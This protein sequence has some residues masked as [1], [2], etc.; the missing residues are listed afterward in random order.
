MRSFIYDIEVMMLDW[1]VVFK[2]IGSGQHVVFH[3]DTENIHD[4]IDGLKDDILI[5]F[6]NKHYDDY[7]LKGIYHGADPTTVKNINDF[8]ILKGK[9]GWEH[10]FLQRKK[11]VFQTADLRDDVVDM[12][13]SL[14]AIEGN[15]NLSIVE[16][17]VS[18]DIDH[19]MTP[20]EVEETIFYCKK[21]VDATE[22]LFFQRKDYMDAK[23]QIAEMYEVDVREAMGMTNAKLCA[24]ILNAEATEF[25]D[26]RDYQIPDA[27]DVSKIPKPIM[28]FFS[29]IWD[30]SIPDEELWSRSLEFVFKTRAGECPCTYAW[31]GAHGAKPNYVAEAT[32]D[33]LIENE[34]VGSLYPNSALNFGFTSRA[35]SDRD[36]YR[37]LV[38][39]RLT[40][41]H[42]GNKPKANAL[43][44]PINTYYGAMLNK[45]NPL[46]DPKMGRSIC[47]TNQLAM[48]MLVVTLAE[49]CESFDLINYN[50]D[51]IMYHISKKEQ[52]KAHQ[53][54]SDWEKRTGFEM[55]LDPPIKKIIQKDVNNYIEVREDGSTKCKGGYVNIV[56][57]GSF[58]MNTLRIVQ[59]AVV[60]FLTDGTPIEDTVNN[61]ENIHD[62]QMIAKTGSTYKKCIHIQNDEAVDV[63]KVNRVY[64]SKDPSLGTLYKVK[65]TKGV[66]RRDKVANLPDHCIVDN[67]NQLTIDQIDRSYYIEMAKSRVKDFT[68][69]KK[70]VQKKIENMEV[71][72]IM[73]TAKTTTKTASAKE[74][75]VEIKD[76]NVFQRL[77]KARSEFLTTP[78][79]KSGKN[80]FAKFNYFEL[81]DIIPVAHPI[82]DK[83][84]LCFHIT[85]YSDH[86]TA[87][88]RNVDDPEDLIEF[89]TPIIELDVRA[90]GMNSNQALGA[91]ETY[92]RRR[93]W[94]TMLELVENDTIDATSGDPKNEP[95]QKKEEKSAPQRPE[96][97]A[98]EMPDF[99]NI[100]DGVDEEVEMLTPKTTTAIKKALKDLRDA[101]GDEK[102]IKDCLIKMK[103]NNFFEPD[104]QKMLVEITEKL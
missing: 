70:A 46:Y 13:L 94:M 1:I 17:S 43:K 99:M 98:D 56:D 79:K 65:Y 28:D 88:L 54:I 4:F 68:V 44:L 59:E 85:F 57:G 33:L 2:E 40:Y 14:K 24:R 62:F 30:E 35:T 19:K 53:I 5:G 87:V 100:P 91:Q 26:E 7:V 48:T 76:L 96:T 11:K 9:Q 60:R 55:E 29:Q 47:I 18:F 90:K 67:D 8:I 89:Q 101:G 71:I 75:A 25:N 12:G 42:D 45:Y 36:G 22:M 6:N 58:K 78:M 34:D 103:S 73:A 64:A 50:T 83:F 66:E 86:A 74:S 81:D 41:K 69:I 102:Y 72:E 32:D 38:S 104:G 63:N 37:N 93:L 49:E 23:K 16:S 39:T 20:E 92:A 97:P 51:G 31:G 84:G 95:A 61:C 10:P 15:L 77:N 21:D 82:L 80:T 3:N 52:E 27:I